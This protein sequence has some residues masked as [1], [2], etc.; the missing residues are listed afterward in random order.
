MCVF[1]VKGLLKVTGQK[2]FRYPNAI[3]VGAAIKPDPANTLVAVNLCSSQDRF[4]IGLLVVKLIQRFKLRNAH[5]Y[6]CT[7]CLLSE[8]IQ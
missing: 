2:C 7:L 4:Q 5:V 3:S 8:N 1:K 6:M